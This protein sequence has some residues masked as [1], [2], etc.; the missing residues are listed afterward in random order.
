M[1]SSSDRRFINYHARLRWCILRKGGECQNINCRKK[2]L[3]KPWL[4]A[5]HHRN[6]VT[7]ITTISQILADNDLTI[8]AKE[9]DKCDLLCNECHRILHTDFKRHKRL[10]KS[11]LEACARI[12]IE[13]WE[14]YHVDPKQVLSLLKVGKTLKEI[15]SLIG[16][17][18]RT[19]RRTIRRLE[20]CLGKKL[21]PTRKESNLA[22]Q[23][24]SDEKL[25]ELRLANVL[26]D[27]ICKDYNISHAGV[28]QRIF[29]LRRK[30]LLPPSYRSLT[31]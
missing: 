20:I 17:K 5:F 27:K 28:Y 15:S 19:V 25:I 16:H 30:G 31:K 3:S 1:I 9:L 10:K 24:I 7:K 13:K 23:K 21:I 6:R 11:I 18:S 22:R 14:P 12:N 26:I 4:A 2:L 8:L 29:K